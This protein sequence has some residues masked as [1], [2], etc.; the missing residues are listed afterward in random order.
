MV[1]LRIPART[2]GADES[3]R[4]PE[5]QSRLIGMLS[6][7]SSPDRRLVLQTPELIVRQEPLELADPLAELGLE[8]ALDLLFIRS[9]H[10]HVLPLVR[11]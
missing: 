3:L 9:D 2:N 1:G 5:V 11:G 6:S 7:L 10:Q 8:L 4:G